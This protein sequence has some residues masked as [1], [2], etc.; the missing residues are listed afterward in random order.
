MISRPATSAMRQAPIAPIITM[1]S[2]TTDG[3]ASSPLPLPSAA[4]LALASSSTFLRVAERV[5]LP[6]EGH[7]ALEETSSAVT[8]SRL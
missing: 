5:W 6:L 3:G 2:S 4:R 8:P 1:A 7:G